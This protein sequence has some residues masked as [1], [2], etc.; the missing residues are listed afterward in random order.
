LKYG[1]NYTGE[2]IACGV[3]IAGHRTCGRPFIYYV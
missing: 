2:L 1:D 3:V